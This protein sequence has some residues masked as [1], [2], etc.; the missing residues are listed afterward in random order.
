[1]TSEITID[2]TSMNIVGNWTYPEATITKGLCELCRCDILGPSPEN[3]NVSNYTP[4]LVFG[5]CK[6][7]FHKECF[8]R[9]SKISCPIDK[10]PWVVEKEIK[11]HTECA[12]TVS[13]PKAK[14]TMS[15]VKVV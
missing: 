2:I 15:D 13:I 1:M 12:V 8:D 9:T 7:C 10:T 6:H 11:P 5:K 14:K 3:I 4:T